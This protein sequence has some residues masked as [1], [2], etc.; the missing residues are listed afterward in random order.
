MIKY[1]IVVNGVRQSI[2]CTPLTEQFFDSLDRGG[3]QRAAR[4]AVE[5]YWNEMHSQEER[6]PQSFDEMAEALCEIY[7]TTVADVI[8]TCLAWQNGY[9]EINA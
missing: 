7:E 2:R 3:F 4:S 8:R 5:L 1:Q 6:N 9:N